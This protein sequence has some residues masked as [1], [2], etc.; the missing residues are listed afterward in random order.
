[1]RVGTLPS[2]KDA[3]ALDW[4]LGFKPIAPCNAN[5]TAGTLLFELVL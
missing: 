1:M 3:A 4:S 2:M 5:L